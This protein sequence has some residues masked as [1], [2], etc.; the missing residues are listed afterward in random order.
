MESIKSIYRIGNGPSSSHTMGPKKAAEIFFERH[1]EATSFKVHLYGSLAATGKGH[2]TDKAISDAFNPK[3]VEF[4]WLP[5]I[6]LPI[7]P[8][9][10]K[11]DALNHEGQLIDEW[12][13]YSVG[14]GKIIDETSDL[15]EKQDRKSVV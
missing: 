3:E 9:A 7:H 6:Y 5:E 14:G 13:V 10:L 4:V 2:F 15:N 8:N 12:V 11:L 1:P